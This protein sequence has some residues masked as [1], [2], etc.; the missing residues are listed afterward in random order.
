MIV[1]KDNVELIIADDQFPL[2]QKVGFKV[3][4]GE[5]VD[6]IEKEMK[7]MTVPEL[8]KL[9]EEKG[10]EGVSSLN[11]AELLKVLEQQE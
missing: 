3:L 4:D 7:D 6:T 8:K 2:Y 11:K 5:A 9:A 1:I 10:I